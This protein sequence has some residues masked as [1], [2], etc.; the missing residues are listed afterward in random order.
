MLIKK[1]EF[2]QK[3]RKINRKKSAKNKKK[4]TLDLIPIKSF[5]NE[6]YIEFVDGVYSQVY[7]MNTV[8]LNDISFDE[9]STLMSNFAYLLRVYDDSI[10]IVSSNFHTQTKKQINYWQERLFNAEANGDEKR[11]QAINEIIIVLKL[12]SKEQIN[13]EHYLQIFAS[14]IKELEDK[15]YL[16]LNSCSNLIYTVPL[17]VEQKRDLFADF[18]NPRVFE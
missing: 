3:N 1:K 14:S 9:N 18:N 17:T 13:K 7:K 11:I 8:S 2:D 12:I 6:Q 10:K 15:I 5:T 4:T 16:L